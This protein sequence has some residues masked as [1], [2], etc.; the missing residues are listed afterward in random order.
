MHGTPANSNEFVPLKQKVAWGLGGVSDA[1]SMGALMTMVFP[2]FQLGYGLSPVVI[3]FAIAIS[4]VFDAI[5]D[6]LIGN[7]SDNTRSRFGRRRPYIMAGSVGMM[8]T[9]AAIWMVP[10]ELTNGIQ[11][12]WLTVSTCLFMLAYTVFNIPYSALAYE[13]SSDESERTRLLAF[14]AF[15]AIASQLLPPWIYQLMLLPQFGGTEIAGAKWVGLLVGLVLMAFSLPAALFSRENMKASEQEKIGFWRAA[16][17][18]LQSRPFRF[19]ALYVLCLMA[20][21]VGVSVIPTYINIFHVY[22]GDKVAA[23]KMIGIAGTI[24]AVVGIA[25]TPLIATLATRFS[26][27][28]VLVCGLVLACVGFASSWWFYTPGSP[29]LQLV[30]VGLTSAGLSCAWVLNG[31]FLGDVCDADELVSGL[32][33]EGMFCA[34][35]GL[36][37]KLGAAVATLAGGYVLL[38]CGIGEGVLTPSAATIDRLRFAYPAVTLVALL[39]AIGAL[40]LYPLNA[41]RVHENR[42]LL[43]FRKQSGAKL[44]DL[45]ALHKEPA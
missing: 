19:L 21:L 23:T 42:R 14:R 2:V 43:D 24:F 44:G 39:P 10:T 11:F 6:P 17:L 5:T 32:R 18:S 30:P 45:S 25:A 26:K 16:S 15:F 28:L 35:Y 34:M 37:Y 29:W 13:M 8:F 33:R 20:G 1:L 40:L 3:G 9:Y 31:T 36:V 41:K 38:W 4:R 22:G 27:R 12:A 7:L